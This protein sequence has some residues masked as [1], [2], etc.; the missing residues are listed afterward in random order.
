MK[1]GQTYMYSFASIAVPLIA[2]V[3]ESNSLQ[4]ETRFGN[5]RVF[6]LDI[7][8]IGNCLFAHFHILRAIASEYGKLTKLTVGSLLQMK[9]SRRAARF[10]S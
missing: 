1:R 4:T 8:K 10:S 5:A 7:V 3:V 2:L 6:C 9:Q